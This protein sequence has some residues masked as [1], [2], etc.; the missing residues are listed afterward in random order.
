MKVLSSGEEGAKRGTEIE[1]S[2][3]FYTVKE[4]LLFSTSSSC[5]NKYYKLNGFNS[6]HLFLTIPKAGNPK[7]KVLN[8]S[9]SSVSPPADGCL[10]RYPHMAGER[11]ES[12]LVS[13]LIKALMPMC[14][15]HLITSSKP[16]CLPKASTSTHHMWDHDF[17]IWIATSYLEDEL[18]Q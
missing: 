11:G 14:G 12:S 1:L 10:L 13:L 2:N 6:K 8:N 3:S 17:S 7:I 5:Q 16:N 4:W 18:Q 9:V 15:F